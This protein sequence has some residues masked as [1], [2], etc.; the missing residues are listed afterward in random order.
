[1]QL[2]PY[3]F[4]ELI[5][6]YLLLHLCLVAFID[7]STLLWRKIGHCHLTPLLFEGAVNSGCK[8]AYCIRLIHTCIAPKPLAHHSMD[9]FTQTAV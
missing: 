4:D 6:H 5:T 8:R 9:L 3:V 1:M 7:L 2:L